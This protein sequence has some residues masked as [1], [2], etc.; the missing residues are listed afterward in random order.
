MWWRT[1]HMSF[2]FDCWVGGYTSFFELTVVN[3][4][5]YKDNGAFN[6]KQV[7]QIISSDYSFLIPSNHSKVWEIYFEPKCIGLFCFIPT[8]GLNE[9]QTRSSEQGFS[10]NP[11]LEPSVAQKSSN[12]SFVEI[13]RLPLVIISTLNVSFIC[14]IYL[15]I[16]P[17]VYSFSWSTCLRIRKN[18]V[19]HGT[20]RSG[21]KFQVVLRTSNMID[22]CLVNLICSI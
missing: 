22:R 7:K 17:F 5:F 15:Y 13:F 4:T 12:L 2:K 8:L 16:H 19:L 1:S 10:L 9:Y 6:I 14:K 11:S 20:Y 3:S 18:R 21:K